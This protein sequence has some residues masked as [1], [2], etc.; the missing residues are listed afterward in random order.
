[1]GSRRRARVSH[2]HPFF[3]TFTKRFGWTPHPTG[4]R[5]CHNKRPEFRKGFD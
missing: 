3:L 1:M 5:S 4:V 2:F